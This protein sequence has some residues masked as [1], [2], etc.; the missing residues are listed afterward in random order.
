MGTI[1]TNNLLNARHMLGTLHVHPV[2]T[3]QDACSYPIL[4]GRHSYSLRQED[5]GGSNVGLLTPDLKLL[6]ITPSQN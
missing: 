1:F 6:H 5:P 4:L 3:L 2:K